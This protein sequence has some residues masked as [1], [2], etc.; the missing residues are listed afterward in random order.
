[1]VGFD[2]SRL[3]QLL[4]PT[5]SSVRVPIR[6][7]AAR[8]IDTIVCRLDEPGRDPERITLTTSLVV[9]DS[10]RTGD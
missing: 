10:S 8:A 3:C 5:L 1:V 2:D 7:G 6:E 4:R 9:R